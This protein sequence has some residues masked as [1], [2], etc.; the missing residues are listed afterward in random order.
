MVTTI[1][2]TAEK[3]QAFIAISSKCNIFTLHLDV[4]LVEKYLDWDFLKK[5]F[6][7]FKE[8]LDLIFN[9]AKTTCFS[10]A[11]LNQN[12]HVLPLL[13]GLA[14]EDSFAAILNGSHE[15]LS[16]MRFLPT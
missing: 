4:A 15:F 6:F 5:I 3:L 9:Q 10:K 1:V 2:Q 16:L 7:W 11:P 12:S 13:C 8:N 14:W